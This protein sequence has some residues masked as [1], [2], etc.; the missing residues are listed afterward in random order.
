VSI[1]GQIQTVTILG[2]TSDRTMTISGDGK[3]AVFQVGASGSLTIDNVSIENGSTSANDWFFAG[4]K[5]VLT[6]TMRLTF[7]GLNSLTNGMPLHDS[8]TTIK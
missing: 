5:D 1:A 2:Q 8:I 3:S 7:P 4:K 6:G